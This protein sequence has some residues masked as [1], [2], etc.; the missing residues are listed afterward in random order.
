M[1]ATGLLAKL[2]T[3]KSIELYAAIVEREL[4]KTKELYPNVP[5]LSLGHSLGGLILCLLCERHDFEKVIFAGAPFRGFSKVFLKFEIL[6]K[7]FNVKIFFQMKPGSKFL[8]SLKLPSDSIVILGERD[9]VINSYPTEG[10][11]ISGLW[12][13]HMFPYEEKDEASSAIPEVMK[14][15]EEMRR[16]SHS[17]FLFYIKKAERINLS[18]R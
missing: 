7:L 12:G 14:I 17:P 16:K 13:H 9:K 18:V 15:I 5:I 11:R 4:E 8:K 1:E 2:K 6:A 10:T 3:K